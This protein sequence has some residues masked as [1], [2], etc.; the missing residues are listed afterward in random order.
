M[1]RVSQLK[2]V[3]AVAAAKARCSSSR[4]VTCDSAATLL[5]TELPRLAPIT[6][7]MASL[8][9]STGGRHGERTSGIRSAS[10]SHYIPFAPMLAVRKLY[11][12]V[13][14]DGFRSYP[15]AENAESSDQGGG[16]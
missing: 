2:S 15:R 16:A 13:G 3:C 4:R 7:G 14:Y 11:V 1:T 8:T 10:R 9:L 5:V 6:I 12:L